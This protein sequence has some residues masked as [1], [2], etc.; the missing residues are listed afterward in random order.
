MLAEAQK[1]KG[2]RPDEPV[3]DACVM[4]LRHTSGDVN[5]HFHYLTQVAQGAAAEHLLL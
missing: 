2:R 1:P 4:E 3:D 5:R